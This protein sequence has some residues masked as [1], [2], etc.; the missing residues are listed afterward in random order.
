MPS[1]SLEIRCTDLSE[2]PNI[3]SQID[4]SWPSYSIWLLEGEMG[5]GKTTFSKAICAFWGVVDIVSSP[6]FSIINEYHTSFGEIIYHFDFYRIKDEEEAEDI[7]TTEYFYS[8]NRC[9]IEWPLK[10]PHLIPSKHLKIELLL[11][12]GNERIFRI[13][14]Y[15][16]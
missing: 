10:I 3:A 12:D 8:G 13:T 7:G 2:L 6:T 14:P 4:N 1:K 5:A 11:G 9:L 15:G 16:E